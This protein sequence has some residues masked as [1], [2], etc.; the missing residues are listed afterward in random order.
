MDNRDEA[1]EASPLLAESSV[2]DP[3]NGANGSPP[4][5]VEANGISKKRQKPAGEEESQ[6]SDAERA[7]QYEGMPDVKAKLK[8]ILP[9]V[10]IG[11]CLFS[12]G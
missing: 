4:L 2:P 9:A 7:A 10:G 11:V 12:S 3:V 5:A 6:N 1:T 8:Y